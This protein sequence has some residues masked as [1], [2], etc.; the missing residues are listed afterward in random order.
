MTQMIV[1]PIELWIVIREEEL[2]T[3]TETCG[4]VFSVMVAFSETEVDTLASWVKSIV[5][6]DI[7]LII[8][9]PSDGMLCSSSSGLH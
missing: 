5:T 4:L 3:V 2:S 6:D 7:K 9:T 1:V 8:E